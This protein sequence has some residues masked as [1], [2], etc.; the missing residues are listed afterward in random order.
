M[1]IRRESV[2][3]ASTPEKVTKHLR[4]LINAAEAA[5]DK[6]YAPYSKFHVGAALELED[7]KIVTGNNQENAAYPSGLCAER[8]AVFSAKANYP[9]TAIKHV[10]IVV[11]T[12][13]SLKQGFTPPCGSCLQVL[14]DVQNRQQSPIQIHVQSPEGEVYSVKDVNQFL[15]FGFEF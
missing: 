14:W 4:G 8:V 7:G 6:A 15:P 3:T 1:E 11:K 13:L 5:A 10:T 12:D 2:V 9:D